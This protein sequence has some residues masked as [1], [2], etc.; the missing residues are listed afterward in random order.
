MRRLKL[1]KAD[2]E[3]KVQQKTALRPMHRQGNTPDIS[4]LFETLKSGSA[5][6]K[7]RG[8]FE[9]DLVRMWNR[10]QTQFYVFITRLSRE[11]VRIQH[12]GPDLTRFALEIIWCRHGTRE[13]RLKHGKHP[14]NFGFFAVEAHESRVVT[15]GWWLKGRRSPKTHWGWLPGTPEAWES[16]WGIRSP[17][18][19]L[20]S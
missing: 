14:L 3:R 18:C 9:K 6:Q 16:T 12:E 1:H 11:P 15:D 10:L 8:S 4:W 2:A 7:I 20:E 17:G 5:G 19:K 13:A